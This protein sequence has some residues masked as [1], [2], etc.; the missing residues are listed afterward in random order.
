MTPETLNIIIGLISLILGWWARHKGILK[1]QPAP[2]TPA[3]VPPDGL[4][5][6]LARLLRRLDA[7]EAKDAR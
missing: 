3:P 2:V 1:P 5:E 7:L 6:L 4:H